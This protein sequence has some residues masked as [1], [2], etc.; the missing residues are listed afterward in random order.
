MSEILYYQL[1]DTNVKVKFNHP[2]FLLEAINKISPTKKLSF[3]LKT[4]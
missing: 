2:N 4:Y 1:Q 3:T